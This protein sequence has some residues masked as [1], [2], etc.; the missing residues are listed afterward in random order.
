MVPLKRPMIL[1]SVALIIYFNQINNDGSLLFQLIF[2]ILAFISIMQMRHQIT[3]K[4]LHQNKREIKLYIQCIIDSTV[5]GVLI[6]SL[7]QHLI[8]HLIIHVL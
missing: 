3:N 8:S 2:N 7:R 6:L 4:N 5:Y 1:L